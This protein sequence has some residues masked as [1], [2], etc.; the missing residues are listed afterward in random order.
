MVIEDD[1]EIGANAIIDR[2]TLD[3]TIIGR[4]TK[5]NNLCHIGHN[6]VM[7]KNCVI[8]VHSYAGGSSKIGDDSWLAPGAIIRD[9]IRIGSN[10]MIG[11]GSVVTKDIG[12]NCVAYGVPTRVVREKPSPE[13]NSRS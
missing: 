10:V 3:S 1:V 12:D 11:M 13:G 8:G 7:D 2:G 6:V 9:G 4:G 5:I